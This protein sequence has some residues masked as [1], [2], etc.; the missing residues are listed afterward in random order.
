MAPRF[1]VAEPI[2]H[3]ALGA[4][5]ALPAS[6]AHHV[7]V[8]RLPDDAAL[9]LF[10]GRGGE[11]SARLLSTDRRDPRAALER[12]DPVERESPLDLTLLQAIAA[13]DAMDYAVRKAVE[14]GVARI[15]PVLTA[16][17]APFP[18]GERGARRVLHWQQV[19]I[20]ACEQCGRN[21]VPCVAP[22]ER[23]TDLDL[24]AYGS[25][26]VC[27]PGDTLPLTAVA[28]PAGACSVLVGPEGGFTDDEVASLRARGAEPVTLGPRVLRTETAA[29]VATAL[30][31]A[32]FGDLGTVPR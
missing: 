11:F 28:P 9:V 14:L 20:A 31:Q 26:W 24:R 21:R 3:D 30:L 22:P 2:P 16:R 7:R 8:M 25:S 32:R 17:S 23:V 15:V 12:F 6:V 27:A 29:V 19:A 4:T 10:D 18:S 1:Y 5:I 13:N